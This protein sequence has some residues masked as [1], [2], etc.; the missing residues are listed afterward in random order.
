MRSL[1]QA[2]AVDNYYFFRTATEFGHRNKMAFYRIQQRPNFLYPASRP[3]CGGTDDVSRHHEFWSLSGETVTQESYINVTVLTGF[4]SFSSAI[5][6]V[7]NKL[8]SATFSYKPWRHD[9]LVWEFQSGAAACPF[10]HS[11]PAEKFR[12]EVSFKKH[13]I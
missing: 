7:N 9:K 12:A 5:S 10:S 1:N 4:H 6:S 8:A 3:S 11:L 2:I 13:V